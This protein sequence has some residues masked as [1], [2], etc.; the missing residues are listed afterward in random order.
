MGFKFAQYSH[1]DEPFIAH[2]VMDLVSA[3]KLHYE[4]IINISLYLFSFELKNCS[5]KCIACL[6]KNP[7]YSCQFG[8]ETKTRFPSRGYLIGI[9]LHEKLISFQF[10][11]IKVIALDNIHLFLGF[12]VSKFA[13]FVCRWASLTTEGKQCS[14]F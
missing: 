4:S 2:L 9:R 6:A 5:S 13:H 11:Q 7:R 14:T 1:L 10:N 8:S 3:S 12:H